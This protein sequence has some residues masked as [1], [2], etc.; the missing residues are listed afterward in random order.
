M[1]LFYDVHNRKSFDDC[2]NA[3]FPFN[4]VFAL[5]NHDADAWCRFES[6]E[7]ADVNISTGNNYGCDNMPIL[8]IAC[9]VQVTVYTS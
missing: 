7:L 2:S 5:I 4:E 6:I 8:Y 9:K 1:T 3:H